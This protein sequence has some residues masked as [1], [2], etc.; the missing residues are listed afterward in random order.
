M[1]KWGKS[2]KTL[3]ETLL[4][5]GWT[6]ARAARDSYF[7]CN[8][9]NNR[10][11]A[12]FKDEQYCWLTGLFKTTYTFYIK[13]MKLAR[14]KLSNLRDSKYHCLYT[15]F[16]CEYP[17]LK[18]F[19]FAWDLRLCSICSWFSICVKSK[20]LRWSLYQVSFKAINNLYQT[21]KTLKPILSK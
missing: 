19:S 15:G 21:W 20:P 4:L 9:G 1:G 7:L 11:G 13:V 16:Y 12:Q 10:M 2:T 8:D 6:G 17:G 3:R 14:F 18:L 5:S